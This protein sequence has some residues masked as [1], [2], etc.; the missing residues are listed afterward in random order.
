MAKAAAISDALFELAAQA[1][2][3]TGRTA[4]SQIECQA[5]R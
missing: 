5:G 1:S 3:S 4:D 2:Q